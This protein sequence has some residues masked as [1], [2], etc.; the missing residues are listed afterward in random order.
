VAKIAWVSG[1]PAHYMRDLHIKLEDIYS[2]KL[3]FFYLDQDSGERGYEQGDLPLNIDLYPSGNSFRFVSLIRQIYNK[4]PDVVILSSHYPWPIFFTGMFFLL[5]GKKVCYWSDTNIH[6]IWLSSNISQLFRKVVMFPFLKS[7]DGL[8]Y[9]GKANKDY[10]ISIIG[11]RLFNKKGFFVPYPHNHDKF[12]S[13]NNATNLS[14]NNSGKFKLIS[15]SRLIKVKSISNVIHAISMLPIDML[16]RLEYVVIGEGYERESIEQDI[17]KYNL[18]NVVSLLGAVNSE[19]VPI[20]IMES[21]MLILPSSYEPWGLVVNEAMSLGVPVI[22]PYWVG[23]AQ[24]LVINGYTGVLLENNNSL[25]LSSIIKHYVNN[26]DEVK[27][28]SENCVRHVAMQKVC[29]SQ[30][31]K[32]IEDMITTLDPNN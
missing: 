14:G 22:A 12:S 31:I 27:V 5:I 3:S 15:V 2:D 9:M 26:I 29:L 7:V 20:H 28:L 30:S 18:E 21:N 24:D 25:S 23:S 11:R 32:G 4:S 17:E 10:Y 13:F 6:D 8:M 19:S 1:F 16:D